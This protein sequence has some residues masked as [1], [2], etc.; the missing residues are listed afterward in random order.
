MDTPQSWFNLQG[1]Q[2][3]IE[4]AKKNDKEKE[5]SLRRLMAGFMEDCPL[6]VLTKA[7]TCVYECRRAE[8]ERP[9]NN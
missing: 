7:A 9:T 2:E 6:D 4:Q 1:F 3:Y 5:T 8:L